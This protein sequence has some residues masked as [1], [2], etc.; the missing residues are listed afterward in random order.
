LKDGYFEMDNMK[1]ALVESERKA[2]EL[3]ARAAAKALV[4]EQGEATMAASRAMP[5]TPTE[6]ATPAR[7]ALLD[8]LTGNGGVA[9]G[10][11]DLLKRL[12]GRS[13]SGS[14]AALATEIGAAGVEDGFFQRL[15]HASAAPLAQ[16]GVALD[17][18]RSGT[19]GR[20]VDVSVADAEAFAE[21]G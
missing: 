18:G 12:D 17:S 10:I 1:A 6:P 4:I 2:A 9:I 13:W 8:A 11:F 16:V 5:A 20:Y 3:A 14:P 19:R 21:A 7:K 15:V